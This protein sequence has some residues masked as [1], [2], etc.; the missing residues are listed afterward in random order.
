AH[1][2]AD[3]TAPAARRS[4]SGGQSSRQSGE[5]TQIEQDRGKR[6]VTDAV[7]E[8][9]TLSES[10]LSKKVAAPHAHDRSSVE[11]IMLHV[12][13]ALV[14]CT[15]FG[16]YLFGWPALYL[17]LTTCAAA[18]ITEALCLKA[19]GAPLQRLRDSSAMLTGWLLALS[20]PP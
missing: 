20:L 14:P 19:I 3:G 10:V 11:R 18:V 15:V 6:I 17:L 12:C 13:L 7:S 2:N 4:R 9:D 8:T 5:T 1:Q 16:I